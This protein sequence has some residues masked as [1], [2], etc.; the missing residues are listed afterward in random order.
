LALADSQLQ[1]SRLLAGYRASLAN[2]RSIML[3]SEVPGYA[4]PIELAI[5]IDNHGRLTGLRVLRQQESPGL[6]SNWSIPHGTGSTSLSARPLTT[7]PEQA[8]AL[9]RDKARSTN[10]LARQSPRGQ[11]D[12][13]QDALRYFDQHRTALLGEDRHE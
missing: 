12:A 1:H 10:W 4:G 11:I 5:A 9:K 6:A 2:T 7:P 13:V 3:R 8:W